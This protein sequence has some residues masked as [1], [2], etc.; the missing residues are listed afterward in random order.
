MSVLRIEQD[1]YD[2]TTAYLT[3]VQPQNVLYAEMFF[4]PQA[5]TT[6]GIAFDTVIRGMVAARR[7]GRS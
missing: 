1:F 4:D 5:H 7:R 2:L 6:R 3:K